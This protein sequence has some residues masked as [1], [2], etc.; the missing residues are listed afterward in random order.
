MNRAQMYRRAGRTLR[1][2]IYVAME[3][4]WSVIAVYAVGRDLFF[5]PGDTSIVALTLLIALSIVHSPK[6]AFVQP[7]W[8]LKA[9]LLGV[10]VFAA[11]LG[12]HSFYSIPSEPAGPAIV[13]GSA[14]YLWLGELWTRRNATFDHEEQ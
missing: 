3:V 10:F 9:I 13:G 14:Y 12:L 8:L 4:A 2:P 7:W 11:A 6:M 5:A 1:Y